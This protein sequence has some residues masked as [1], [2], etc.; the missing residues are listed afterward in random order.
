MSLVP[1]RKK[2]RD[3]AED[4]E[5]LKLVG[6]VLENAQQKPVRPRV[7]LR[8]RLR[9]LKNT[10][11]TQTQKH[12]FV[13][14]GILAG[15]LYLAFLAGVTG[16]SSVANN[17][18]TATRGGGGASGG[19]G[20]RGP[21]GST[22]TSAGSSATAG[23]GPGSGRVVDKDLARR[24]IAQVL[25]ERVAD[26]DYVQRSDIATGRFLKDF[27][28]QWFLLVDVD[29]S[30]LQPARRGKG[31]VQVRG[32][33]NMAEARHRSHLTQT[34]KR[35]KQATEAIIRIV[36]EDDVWKLEHIRVY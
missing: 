19:G 12:P 29:R 33:Y 2:D 10:L 30:Q 17:S 23:G 3:T 9:R 14:V 36:E 24:D 35:W 26:G 4:V 1:K 31:W 25:L 27:E 34:N 15:A 8:K 22:I 18:T 7:S 16:G 20:Y 11:Q 6:A 28:N 13:A 32:P 21:P 5:L